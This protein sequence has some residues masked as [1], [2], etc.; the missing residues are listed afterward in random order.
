LQRVEH[1]PFSSL[2]EIDLPS[3]SRQMAGVR[4]HTRSRDRRVA[5][6]A[7]RARPT[8]LPR[9]DR[10]CHEYRRACVGQ[11]HHSCELPQ[12]RRNR[13]ES[14]TPHA[15][16][17]LQP[18]PGPPTSEDNWPASER[19]E[20][21][22]RHAIAVN[23]VPSCRS[24]TAVGGGPISDTCTPLPPAFQPRRSNCCLAQTLERIP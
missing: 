2:H 14:S 24:C 15:A 20:C 1:A 13:S 21:V 23:Q 18:L 5:S 19:H 9:R 3:Q 8:Q 4:G 22:S 11:Q 12:A 16:R 17:A 10:P 6:V 7:S